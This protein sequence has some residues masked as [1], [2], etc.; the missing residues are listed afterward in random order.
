MLDLLAT[1]ELP[2]GQLAMPFSITRPAVSQH[3]H[4]LRRAGLVSV[5]K[6][7]RQHLYR[8]HPEPLREV[9]DWAAHY[10]HFWNDK[11]SSLGNFL[12]ETG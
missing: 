6:R 2:A 9:Y 10:Q 3:L 4:V 1:S 8:L 12:N 7:G 11:L 5:R